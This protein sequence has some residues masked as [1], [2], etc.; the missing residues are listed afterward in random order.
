MSIGNLLSFRL[1]VKV[2]ELKGHGGMLSGC[3]DVDC[4]ETLSDVVAEMDHL[5]EL[6]NAAAENEYEEDEGC[7]CSCCSCCECC[8]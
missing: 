5:L 6:E 7:N 2:H 1:A 4:M 8:H 3:I